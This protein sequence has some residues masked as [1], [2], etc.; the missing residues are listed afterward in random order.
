MKILVGVTGASGGYLG[1]KLAQILYE[2]GEDCHLIISKNAKI[3]MQK[4][5]F[6]FEKFLEKFKGILYENDEIWASPAS[7]SAKFDAMIIAPS[8][9]NSLAKIANGIADNLITRSAAV[10]LKERRR[11]ILGLR[12]SPLSTISLR[13]MAEISAQGVIIAPMMIG[14]YHKPKSLEDIENFIIGKWLDLLG[15]ENDLF[16]RWKN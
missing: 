8:S 1:L 2:K 10:M 14:F 12:E 4:E 15:I 6:E 9:I 5:G 11:L 3:S 7:G 16:L 13:Q